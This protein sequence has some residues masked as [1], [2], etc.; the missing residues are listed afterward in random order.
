MRWTPGGRSADLE[1]RRGRRPARRGMGGALPKMGLGGFLLLLLLSFIFKQDFFALLGGGGEAAPPGASAPVPTSPEEE[2]MVQF[3]SFVLDDVQNT[4]DRAFAE[5]GLEYDRAK[6]VLFTE[7]VDSGCGYAGA[8]SGPFY[9]PADG[10]AYI[11]L[12]FYR[13]LKQRF[14]ASGDFAEAYVLAHEI[15][16]H[17]QNLLG[18]SDAVRQAQ[19]RSPGETNRLSVLL[20]LQADCYA[21]VWGYSTDQREILERGDV[22]EALDAA[23]AIGDDRIQSQTRG[24]VN[25]ESWTHGSSSQRVEWFRTGLETGDPERCDTFEGRLR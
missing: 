12:S 3:V 5:S 8:E 18:T 19:R 16:H 6:L 1:D 21:G 11:D 2:E 23:A 7:A 15:G 10:K 17:V 24:R 13:D 22:E 14:G 25:P 9:C 20:E 4:W